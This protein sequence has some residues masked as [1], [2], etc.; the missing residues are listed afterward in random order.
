MTCVSRHRPV[1]VLG[2]HPTGPAF[3]PHPFFALNPVHGI[4]G[5]LI[6]VN[7]LVDSHF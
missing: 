7:T 6:A 2:G 3:F 5:R 4:S 1:G